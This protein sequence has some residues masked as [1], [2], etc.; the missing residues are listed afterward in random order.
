[1]YVIITV[2]IWPT[3]NL[4]SHEMQYLFNQKCVQND[5]IIIS[6]NATNHIAISVKTIGYYWEMVEPFFRPTER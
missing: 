2:A 3:A 1:M 5:N 6:C 4:K